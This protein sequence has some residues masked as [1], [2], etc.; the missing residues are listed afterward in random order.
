M[1][2]LC[3]CLSAQEEASALLSALA[4]ALSNCR[5]V[6]PAFLPVHDPLRDAWWGI[7]IS[8][9]GTIHYD[10]DSIHSSN[11]PPR[12]LEVQPL[13]RVPSPPFCSTLFCSASFCICGLHG[14]TLQV[15]H[16]LVWRTT[17]MRQPALLMLQLRGTRVKV[18]QSVAA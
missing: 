15:V 4:T 9:H 14:D 13:S 7:A 17:L 11:L 1:G 8:G 16:C 10:S 2:D 3:F 18:C 5:L 12:L 6:W